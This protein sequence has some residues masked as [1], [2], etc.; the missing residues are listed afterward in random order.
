MIYTVKYYL[1]MKKDF[2]FF[3]QSS[4]TWMN[5]ENVVLY[6]INQTHRNTVLTHLHVKSKKFKLAEAEDRTV[7]CL[8]STGGHLGLEGG[9]TR[10]CLSK[11][12][13]GFT[14]R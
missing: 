6:E 13:H 8:L 9:D 14:C 1:A 5:L 2:F 4:T 3:F 10:V 7:V 12:A 11:G